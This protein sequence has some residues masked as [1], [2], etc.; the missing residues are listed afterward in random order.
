MPS[1]REARHVDKQFYITAESIFYEP[2]D[3]VYEPSNELLDGIA[4]IV[5]GATE[6]WGTW[7]RGVWTHVASLS[8]HSLPECGWKIHLSATPDNCAYIL[9][10][11]SRLCIARRYCFKFAN[12]TATLRM[13]SSKRWSRGGSGKFITIYPESE[14]R[15][16]SLIKDVYALV[17]HQ[18]G[19]YI[20]SD[21]RYKDCRCLY[22][23]YGSILPRHSVDLMGQKRAI[24]TSPDGLQETIDDRPP[25][26][27][28]PPWVSD[29]LASKM[30]KQENPT[31]SKGRYLVR[32]A[33]AFSNTGGVYLAL[34]QR[35]KCEVV[36]KEAR[37][38]VEFYCNGRDA[39]SRLQ[40]EATILRRLQATGV[41]PAV[42]DE[43][44]DWENYFVVEEY[45][46]DTKDIR[47]FMLQN[48]PLCQVRPDITESRAFYGTCIKIFSNL[49]NAIERIHSTGVVIGDLSPSNILINTDT[50]AVRIIDL[51]GAHREG[52]DTPGDLY[53]P[54]F[55]RT[56]SA[57]QA[58]IA[59]DLYAA[60]ATM[61]YSMF[62]LVVLQYLRDDLFDDVLSTIITDIGW[63][64]A[65][66][67]SVIHG[68]ATGEMSIT[69][70]S[71]ALLTPAHVV[72]PYSIA[73][74]RTHP[75]LNNI[76][77]GMGD[78][79][80]SSA[81]SDSSK[82]LFPLDPFA[83]RT[84]DLSLGFGSAGI[85]YSL[86]K[87][88]IHP[89]PEQETRF[90]CEIARAT[91]MDLAPGLLTGASGIAM[92]LFAMGRVDAAK[93]TLEMSVHSDLLENSHSLYYGKAGIGMANLKAFLTTGEQTY[94]DRACT[95]G[96]LLAASAIDSETSCHW[97]TN[98]EIHIGFGYG[99]SGV[100]LFLLRLSQ[101]SG[102]NR[103][104][105]LGKRALNYDLDHATNLDG[106]LSFP[107]K[108]DETM[109]FEE[110]I[111][112]GT[113]GV[114]K[115]AVRYGLWEQVERLCFDLH[116]K[117]SGFPGLIYGLSGFID[118][119]LDAYLYSGNR[120][121]LTMLQRPLDGIR[122]FYLIKQ[123]NGYAVPGEN[124]FRISCDYATGICGVMATL[125]RL[126]KLSKDELSLDELD[127]N[128]PE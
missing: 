87:V 121:Y 76:I 23:R 5:G 65:P 101:V 107:Y 127:T 59:G 49:L 114:V 42:I 103:W 123:G 46:E 73:I 56:G 93:A 67:K 100:A 57:H 13:M 10:L 47:Q 24:L 14:S 16:I 40:G 88:G 95:L 51:E 43:F 71:L 19:S 4:E 77:H 120:K 33:L 55:R 36:I 115:V 102:D 18:N 8:G 124:L 80:L 60:A 45:L 50:F 17:R 11:V 104:R 119:L 37:P 64:D 99:Q 6:E 126:T 111:E 112:Q 15:F 116:R 21:R 117:Y 90:S 25:Y 41:T 28:M 54:G 53:T 97:P 118:V 78:F 38:F 98:D 128:M 62:P 81:R 125:N 79:V 72:A 110:Y 74:E 69:Q 109:T 26:F 91:A 122:D 61:L 7:R 113:A 83:H 9:E 39:I 75:D 96:R 31:L 34:D 44:W 66:I 89:S 94:L 92:A 1:F 35:T 105:D 63:K 12:D 30:E 3:D 106:V 29:P 48:S 20:L 58:T 85:M 86:F 32:K 84:N 22:Y 68:L 70:A 27:S 52:I 2:V 82:T 108:S